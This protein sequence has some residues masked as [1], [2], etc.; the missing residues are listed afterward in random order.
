MQASEGD[1]FCSACGA[2]LALPEGAERK[3]ATMLFADIVGSTGIAAGA[4][5]EQLRSRLAPFF[6]STRRIIG[7]HGGT[8]EKFIGDAVMAVFGVPRAH[9]DDADRAIAAGLA[10]AAR[11]GED[12]LEIRVGVETGEVLA[13][14]S[15][16]DLAVTGDAVNAA[17]R[18]QTAA[19]AGEV[20][21]GAR[22][23][24]ASRRAELEGPRQ[25]EAKGFPE[26]LPAWRATRMLDEAARTETPF[27]GR[28]DDLEL[29][30]LVYRR[31]L[32]ERVP[33]LITIAGEAGIGKSRLASELFETLRETEPKP[34]I[35]VG[36]N[37]PYGRGIA[38]WALGEILRSAAGA[39]P[40]D[41]VDAVRDALARRLAELGA[42]DAESV[43]NSL[44]AAMGG[45]ADDDAAGRLK[46]GWRRLV[47]LLALEGPVVIGIDDAHWA[48]DDLLDL[49]EEAA[50]RLEDAPVLLLCTSR[51]ELLDRRP[52]FGRSAR[53][54]TQIELRPLGNEAITELA[55][56][57]L[58]DAQSREL[59]EGVARA[60]GGN[61]FFA[62]E[63]ACRIA[64]G[65][66]G[67]NGSRPGGTMPETVQAAISARLDLLPADEK[68]AV[69][70]AAVLGHAFLAES[71]SELLQEPASD[72]LSQL[73]RRTLLTERVAEG[74][75]RFAFRHQLIRDV[76]YSSL[77]RSQRA[78]L[79][80]RAADGIA[81]RAGARYPELA[82]LVAYHRVEAS[83]LA[84]S[85]ERAKAA[86]QASV[87]AAEVASRRG[88]SKRAQE[89]FEQAVELAPGA[90]ERIAGL[91]SAGLLAIRRFRGDE[92]LR[93]ALEE[94]RLAEESGEPAAAAA[95]F[96]QAVEIAARMGG[97]T[98]DVPI[99]ELRRM[100]SRASELVDPGDQLTRAQLRLDEAW[101][102]WR[103]GEPTG[104][105]EPAREA[106]EMAREH[107]ST[108]MLSSAMDA[109]TAGYWATWRYRDAVDM[110]LERWDLL[111]AAGESSAAMD[112]ELSDA[113]H[114]VVESMLQTGQFREAAKHAASARD[115]DLSR[116]VVY[117][118]WARG[119]TPAWYLGDW[120]AALE[121]GNKVRE[122][123]TAE[124][125]PPVTVLASSLACAAA[126]YEIR[127]VTSKAR[128]WWDFTEGLLPRN[129]GQNW[130][131]GVRMLH[132]QALLHHGRSDEAYEL[133]EPVPELW[134]WWA[135]HYLAVRAEVCCVVRAPGFEEALAGAADVTIQSPYLQGVVERARGIANDDEDSLRRALAFFE[136]CGAR[137]DI[138]R[139]LWLLGGDDR[140]RAREIYAELKSPLPPEA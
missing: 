75:G 17:A 120:D 109:V 116:G 77:P 7:E 49:I 99:E 76:A 102:A 69:Q 10:L 96:G 4:D 129:E 24:R 48:D 27:L 93:L 80:E 130:V 47:A 16:G 81:G 78:A 84:P 136:G 44:A 133:V 46:S 79:H 5:P 71:L 1:R 110:A 3:L 128:D 138:A 134:T 30:R 114:M 59:V 34:T 38:L 50:F 35:L 68:R 117:S 94:A 97:I 131:H 72:L 23:A 115:A 123:W 95:A 55:E 90:P 89:L 111:V 25:V 51:P 140:N 29:L 135:G 132:A 19:D 64:D 18:L 104:M 8:V 118:G 91:R 127:G 52:T 60:S 31:A 58:D 139:T 62:E 33:E 15:G 100:H 112:V 119:L 126:I 105:T 45:S 121:M 125:R 57:L 56:T 88:A 107:G 13:I 86:W 41:S 9:G 36:R 39:G 37:P 92:A 124:N 106:L 42:E 113:R 20:L 40:D 22:A 98:G 61:P 65:G 74:G 63:V 103:A 85:P 26:P 101:I 14:D 28:D 83:T 82:E 108:T 2:P 53:N 11:L 87:D 21:V 122:A 54:V 137:L 6:E 70:Y 66:G 32:R 12:G 43:A 73:V 67:G